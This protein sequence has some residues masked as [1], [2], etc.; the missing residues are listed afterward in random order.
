MRIW[1]NRTAM[2][3]RGITVAD[4]EKTLLSENVENPGGRIESSERE[5]VVRLKRQ[6]YTAED[7]R[8]M[9]LKRNGDGDYIRLGDVASV[10]VDSR[11]QRQL[12]TANKQPM[13]GIGI[14]KQSTANTLTVSS[15]ARALIRELEKNLPEGMAMRVLRDESRFINASIAEV[16][17]SLIVSAILV[18][19]IIFLF[20]G[21]L[22][23][24][25]IPALTVPISLI[26]HEHA[27]LQRESADPAGSCAGD[28]DGG[29][30]HHCRIGEHPPQN[31]RRRA[32]AS[33]VGAR[34]RP[35]G[36]RRDRNDSRACRRIH[37][38]LPVDGKDRQTVYRVC[39]GDDGVGLFFQRGSADADSD[40]LF[41]IV[42]KQE[43]RILSCP[44][45]GLVPRL[46]RMAL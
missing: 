25:V 9:V 29:G 34:F 23:A 35:G 14:Y 16:E 30:R 44:R 10:A 36:F 45:G 2:A 11:N 31:R 6:Y 7:F 33:G 12:F 1:L 21:S 4:I 17:D 15:G 40:A 18:L 42:E 3:A 8:N 32:S 37:A 24:S 41:Q 19:L 13:I 38:D 26:A 46:E 22:R 20:L 5:F 43:Q 28:R 39:G 27:G